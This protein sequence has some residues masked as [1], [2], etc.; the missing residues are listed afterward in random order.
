MKYSILV[1]CAQHGA[2][3]PVEVEAPTDNA[4]VDRA[5]ESHE[6]PEEGGDYEIAVTCLEAVTVPAHA[7]EGG[8]KLRPAGT[9]ISRFK[10]SH[11][12]LPSVAEQV[13]AEREQKALAA[14]KAAE[15]EALK[16]ELLL[17]IHQEQKAAAL[18]M[19]VTK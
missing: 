4:A 14:T 2:L 13:Y 17:E 7:E 5:R 10:V 19:K 11:E 6:V 3:K 16:A 1:V 15:R 9:E 12:P 18:G 8:T